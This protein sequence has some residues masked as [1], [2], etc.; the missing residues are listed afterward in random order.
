MLKQGI[1]LG[2]VLVAATV[3]YLPSID[4]EFLL[5]DMNIAADPLVMDP[6]GKTPSDW[7]ASSRP[8]TSLTFALNNLAVGLDP[9]GWH[10][11]NVAIHLAA[12]VL[13]WLFARLTLKR[14]GL[15]RP[16]GPAMAAA[17]LFALHPL[18]T[19][20]VAYITQRAE[21]L[22]SGIYLAAL[23]FLLARDE[24]PT[25][26]RRG[27]FLAGAIALHALGLAVKPILATLPIA[28]LLYAAML[29]VRGEA[30]PWRRMR[31]RAVAALPLFALSVAAAIRAIGGTGGSVTT[32]FHIPGL[33]PGQYFMTQLRVI[34]TYLRLL[35]W[36][37]GQ[38]A[39][40]SFPPSAGFLD[41]AVLGGAALLGAM[42]AAA[43]A[44]AVRL[45]GASG[46]GPA[47]ARA[48][49]FGVLFFLLVLAPSSSVVPLLDTYAEHR[50]YLG[51]LGVFVAA[52]AGAAIA[53][54]K[55][56]P[57]RAAVAGSALALAVVAAAGIATARR[58]AVWT[59]WLEF[60][61]D[62]AGA[63]PPK[64]RAL[65]GLGQ[66]LGD[67]QRHTD[68]LAAFRRARELR[69][70]GSVSDESLLSNIVAALLALSRPDEARA[71]IAQALARTP[72]KPEALAQLALVEFAANR[73]DD[74]ERAALAAISGDP[75]NVTALEVLGKVRLHRGDIG[76]A[77]EA[78]RTAGRANVVKPALYWELGDIEERSGDRAAACA[79][80]ARA[81]NQPWVGWASERARAARSRLGCP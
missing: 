46:D 37:V 15:S 68:A 59:T 81:A 75:K 72:R 55:L 40:R 41:P 43:V 45:R 17:A 49:S 30:E 65:Y 69:A 58:N 78:L 34:P 23:L 35:A 64:A 67:A 56:A 10:L 73:D 39:D 79:A 18:Q 13:A 62:A 53:V 74:A 57:S 6:L 52:S 22:A 31:H 4:G 54:R 25:A 26:V 7:R 8:L 47:A 29:P 66:A 19:E 28:W 63:V 3:A 33:S 21:S 24:D 20:S 16:D 60:W 42:T 27:A 71:E 50:V 48:A 1:L 2:I 32:G 61:S 51:A 9:R 11:T 5:D 14:A 12:V 38:C 36:P 44:A 70:D 76:G 80:Y 77:R